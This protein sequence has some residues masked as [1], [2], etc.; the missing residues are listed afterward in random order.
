MAVTATFT[1][2]KYATSVPIFEEVCSSSISGTYVTGGFTWNPLAI[3]GAKGSS[4]IPASVCYTADFY[5]NN[6]YNYQTTFSGSTATTKIFTSGGTELANG[7]AIP[8]ATPTVVLLKG[9]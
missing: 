3:A 5:G 4:P 9:R 8:D 2:L 7:T 1:R 6:G